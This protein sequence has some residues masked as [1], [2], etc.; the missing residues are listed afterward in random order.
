MKLALDYFWRHRSLIVLVLT[1]T[2]IASSLG[3]A[4]LNSES[5]KDCIRAQ[6]DYDV[7]HAQPEEQT[8]L[9]VSLCL[10]CSGAFIEAHNGAISALASIVIAL[11]TVTLWRATQGMLDATSGQSDAMDKSIKEAARAATAMDRVAFH[12]SENVYIAK[13]RSAQQMRAYL[14]VLVN[15]GTYQER[16]K[17][18]R[19]EGRPAILNA[20][21]TPA[22]NVGY[23]AAA[24][25]LPVPL[26]TDFTF[27][28]KDQVVG[29]ATLGPHQHFIMNATVEDFYDDADV[30]DIKTGKDRALYVWGIVT[31]Q[32]IFGTDQHTKFCQ[33]LLWLPDGRMFGF[34]VSDY[35]DAT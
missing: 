6:H 19:F 13:E 17:N 11:F 2:I 20:G 33:Y 29:A 34:F 26:P 25:I 4:V 9:P 1:S 35:N 15:A 31:Y 28:L 12:F 16:E 14:S 3:F 32:D 21:Q 5:F 18:L 30:F 24:G 7:R 10:P 27:P 8:R 23:R 22:K